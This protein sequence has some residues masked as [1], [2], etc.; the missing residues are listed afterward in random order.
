MTKI[1]ELS[2]KEL[3]FFVRKRLGQKKIV[4]EKNQT[5]HGSE[6]ERVSFHDDNEQNDKIVSIFSDLWGLIKIKGWKGS[7]FVEYSYFENGY[8]QEKKDYAGEGSVQIICDLLKTIAPNKQINLEEQPLN[9]IAVAPKKIEEIL[10]EQVVDY[11]TKNNWI[12]K[13]QVKRKDCIIW[14]HPYTADVVAR[15]P[16]YEKLGWVGFEL[17]NSNSIKETISGLKQIITK[18]QNCV[19]S[20]INTPVHFWVLVTHSK[21]GAY[22]NTDNYNQDFSDIRRICNEFGVAIFEWQKLI[23]P[24]RSHI[25]DGHYTKYNAI[26]F[27]GSNSHDWKIS[28]DEIGIDFLKSKHPDNEKKIVSTITKKVNWGKAINKNNMRFLGDI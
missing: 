4:D 20:E 11:L 7:L 1:K 15:H 19:F 17:K 28:I 18:Y 9:T 14:E 21:F 23:V 27:N 3:D 13:R 12:T 26:S 16:K 24:E 10:E 6:H 22:K 5:I 2:K 8:Q 25:Y